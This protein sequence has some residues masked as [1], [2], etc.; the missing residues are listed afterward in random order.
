MSTEGA[1]ERVPSWWL[2]P[3]ANSRE[4]ALFWGAIAAVVLLA[5]SLRL[6][7]LAP[8]S[9]YLDDAWVAVLARDASL[10]DLLAIRPPHPVGFLVLLAFARRLLPGAEL[11][12][13]LLP[14]AASLALVPLG[15][16]LV[17]RRAGGLAGGILAAVLLALNPAHSAFAVRVK[18]YATDALLSLVLVAA[19]ERCLSEPSAR[20]LGRLALLASLAVLFSYPAALV[21]AVGFAGAF[22]ASVGSTRKRGALVGIA[23]A[24]LAADLFFGFFLVYGQ[25]NQALT[26]YWEGSFV[27]LHDPAAAVAF[28]VSRTILVFASSFPRGFGAL[29]I[30]GLLGFVLLLVNRGTRLAAGLLGAL[31]AAFC[32]AAAMRL[33]PVD[34]RTT[35][36]AYPLV[37]LVAAGTISMPM[38]RARRAV[39]REGVPAF[40]AAAV[41]LTSSSRVEYPVVEDARLV[42]SLRAES[43]PGDTVLIYPHANW[44]AGYY[45]DWPVRLVPV[46]YYGTR[47]ESRLLRDRS[48]TLP[49]RLGYEDH[50]EVLDPALEELVSQ[51]P[52]RVLYL[53][54]HL[55]VKCCAAHVHIREFLG[56]SGYRSERLA[57]SLDGELLRFTRQ[58]SNRGPGTP[59]GLP[60]AG[61][62]RPERPSSTSG[63]P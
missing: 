47:F 55:E 45:G 13:Q 15:A 10:S 41:V 9:L 24:F 59:P 42:R 46:D 21:G 28:I 11:S 19:T 18:P 27:P 37:A 20:R 52:E 43:E 53:A 30:L 44:A 35:A 4:G 38:K 22:L 32:A 26:N 31:W 40:L 29:G 7:G 56:A 1:R 5:L 25:S 50:P 17:R 48:I 6:P 63:G 12:L 51:K 62:S 23:A 36:F 58:P 16:W 14:F 39:V 60:K 57:R 49:G 61:G 54:T 33:Y 3:A 34:G 2:G 8:S